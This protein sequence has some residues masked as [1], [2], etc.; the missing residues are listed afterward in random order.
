RLHLLRG[1]GLLLVRQLAC[2]EVVQLL[3]V[4]HGVLAELLGPTLLVL[5]RAR[6]ADRT[7]GRQRCGT[8][9]R[10][11]RC[12]GRNPGRSP[13]DDRSRPRSARRSGRR[14]TADP[15]VGQF[16]RGEVGAEA[17]A[18]RAFAEEPAPTGSTRGRLAARSAGGRGEPAAAA[19]LGAAARLRAL[20]A[21][22]L[23]LAGAR[24]GVGRA[25]AGRTARPRTAGVT[26]ATRGGLADRRG[27]P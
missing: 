16:L 14:H 1:H 18:E 17:A 12:G 4:D 13:T 10:V 2:V 23:A 11:G 26:R 21:G 27:G 20:R 5:L 22:R 19:L 3:A 6:R 15:A 7:T 8:S 24:T 25:G 9:G